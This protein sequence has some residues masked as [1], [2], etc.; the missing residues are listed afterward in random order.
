MSAL[1]FSQLVRYLI[2]SS[3]VLLNQLLAY[4]KVKG[5]GPLWS[6]LPTNSPREYVTNHKLSYWAVTV[7]GLHSGVEGYP[8]WHVVV[9]RIIFKCLAPFQQVGPLWVVFITYKGATE[10]WQSETLWACFLRVS[11]SPFGVTVILQYFIDHFNLTWL[12][13]H[14]YIVLSKMVRGM[15]FGNLADK[16]TSHA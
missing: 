6:I 4:S 2:P 8:S 1:S 3:T 16:I 7:P 12:L 5:F 15:Q 13:W 11:Y 14:L 10:S 9:H